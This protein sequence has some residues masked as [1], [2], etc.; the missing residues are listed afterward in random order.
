MTFSEDE[1]TKVARSQKRGK[2][3]PSCHAPHSPSATGSGTANSEEL[4]RSTKSVLIEQR[5]IVSHSG[6][7]P[8]VS[9]SAVQPTRDG[10]NGQAR[11]YTKY[12]AS[13]RCAG[14]QQGDG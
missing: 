7:A 14:V 5:S 8:L 12:S 13:E 3:G 4:V 2:L 11:G 1:D 10:G 9:A 6:V